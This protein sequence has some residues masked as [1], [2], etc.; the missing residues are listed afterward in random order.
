MPKIAYET[1]EASLEALLYVLATKHAAKM[2]DTVISKE[3]FDVK[4]KEAKDL[5]AEKQRSGSIG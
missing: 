5:Y 1:V 4:M 2:G 3:T